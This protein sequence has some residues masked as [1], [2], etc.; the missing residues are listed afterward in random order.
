MKLLPR[1]LFT[2]TPLRN[3]TIRTARHTNESSSRT[4]RE[5]HLITMNATSK[6]SSTNAADVRTG[7]HQ[8]KK[9]LAQKVEKL[10]QGSILAL[11]NITQDA[12]NDTRL[13]TESCTSL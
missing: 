5:N 10:E 6:W 7:C 8:I 12:V 4:Y 11:K 3:R 13:S 2:D 9:L 1:E